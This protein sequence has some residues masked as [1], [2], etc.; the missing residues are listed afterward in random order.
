[1]GGTDVTSNEGFAPLKASHAKTVHDGLAWPGGRKL[2][3]V[4]PA[5]FT[6][7]L[8]AWG[9]PD[10]SHSQGRSANAEAYSRHL[11]KLREQ[12]ADTAVSA[13][14]AKAAAK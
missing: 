11:Q 12:A 5:E 1:M 6:S 2:G 3:D 10:A 9:V 14:L 13:W 4:P 8:M 7:S